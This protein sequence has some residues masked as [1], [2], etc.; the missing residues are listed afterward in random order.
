VGD[1]GKGFLFAERRMRRSLKDKG[2]RGRRD[3]GIVDT[4]RGH[5]SGFF[6]DGF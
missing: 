1:A 2:E 6:V 4:G 3:E 5:G